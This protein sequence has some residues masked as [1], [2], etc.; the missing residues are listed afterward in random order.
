LLY[1]VIAS[2]IVLF[3]FGIYIAIKAKTLKNEAEAYKKQRKGA[4]WLILLGVCGVAFGAIALKIDSRPTEE[5]VTP[6]PHVLTFEEFKKGYIKNAGNIK[7]KINFDWTLS[8][9]EK[10]RIAKLEVNKSAQL[11]ISTQKN[12]DNDLIGVIFVVNTTD[13]KELEE[14]L[15]SL[16]AVIK[17]LE[18]NRSIDNVRKFVADFIN[19]KETNTYKSN[20]IVYTKQSIGGAFMLFIGYES[21]EGIT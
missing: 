12:T 8:D 19:Q 18:P 17:T 13:D 14:A 10:A 11:S 5:T 21:Q 20:D 2:G 16:Y 3:I 6:V 1:I 9:G 4:L 7:A 15:L